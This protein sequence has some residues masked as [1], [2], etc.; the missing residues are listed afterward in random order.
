MARRRRRK[1]S[2]LRILLGDLFKYLN[3]DKDYRKPI[4]GAKTNN[5]PWKRKRY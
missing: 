2:I 4:V 3:S 5:K 1:R